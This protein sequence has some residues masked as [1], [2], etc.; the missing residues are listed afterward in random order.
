MKSVFRG[1]LKW[2]LIQKSVKHVQRLLEKFYQMWKRLGS[3]KKTV[4]PFRLENSGLSGTDQKVVRGKLA[5]R[6]N[7]ER[8]MH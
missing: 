8:W 3:Y 7:I 2:V 4:F 6:D 1:V 5:N